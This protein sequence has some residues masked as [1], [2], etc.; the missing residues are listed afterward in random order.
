MDSNSERSFSVNVSKESGLLWGERWLNRSD[1]MRRGRESRSHLHY[2]GLAGF[3]TW[4]WNLSLSCC[5]GSTSILKGYSSNLIQME[6]KN[7]FGG[8]R[9]SKTV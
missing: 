5:R 3:H 8:L 6:L 1:Q 7:N 4:G 2:P 9:A